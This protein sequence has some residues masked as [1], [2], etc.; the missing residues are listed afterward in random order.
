[1]DRVWACSN[2]WVLKKNKNRKWQNQRD[3]WSPP[4]PEEFGTVRG[5]VG[6]TGPD[7]PREAWQR[8]RRED[9]SRD[10]TRRGE[11]RGNGHKGGDLWRR[12]GIK[13]EKLNEKKKKEKKKKKIGKGGDREN[14]P[15]PVLKTDGSQM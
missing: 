15:G 3:L 4:P 5:S 1:V 7:H 6:T 9:T 2:Y 8:A 14:L 10:S 12:G 13:K 11:K